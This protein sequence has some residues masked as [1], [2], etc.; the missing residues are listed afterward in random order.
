MK[1]SQEANNVNHLSCKLYLNT[2]RSY[3]RCAELNCT[4]PATDIKFNCYIILSVYHPE[5]K[6]Q[7]HAVK[8]F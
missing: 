7:L 6:T 2:S 1:F 4:Y 3:K 5:K 8:M